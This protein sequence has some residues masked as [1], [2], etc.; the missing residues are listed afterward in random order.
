MMRALI[1]QLRTEVFGYGKEPGDD[2][3]SLGPGVRK[4]ARAAL[5]HYAKVRAKP[6]FHTEKPHATMAKRAQQHLS[7]R[8]RLARIKLKSRARNKVG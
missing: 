1:E 6:P 7:A 2:R 5:K 3:H 4:Q 8:S